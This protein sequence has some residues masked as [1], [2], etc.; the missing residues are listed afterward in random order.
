MVTQM[1]QRQGLEA[2]AAGNTEVP[3]VAAIAEPS[4]DVFVVE[5]SS[6]RLGH[7]EH[8]RPAVAT[9]LNFAPDHLD[10]HASLSS[11]ERAKARIWAELPPDGVAVANADDEVVMRHVPSGVRAV[12]FGTQAD[13]RVEAGELVGPSGRLVSV[14]E[15]GRALPH[16]LT[17]GL[18]SAATAIAAGAELPAVRSVLESF[19]GL[20]HRVE[21]VVDVGGIAVYDDSKSTVPHATIAAAT[22]FESVVL[23]CGGRNKGLDLSALR[24]CAGHLRSV[25][26]IGEAA[27]EVEAAFSGTVPVTVAPS[28]EKAVASAVDQAHVGDAVLLSPAC[29]SFDWYGSYAERGDD[30]QQ[31]ARRL[32]SGRGRS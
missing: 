10:V 15:L 12:T 16:D 19:R 29:A 1:L 18:A 17:N 24:Q 2:V 27:P 28:M 5:A 9:W 22:A 21:F 7:S 3:L 6:F 11:Y 23:I 31:L 14:T 30:F 32:V 13:Y 8:F 25:V 4:T 20:P 26:A